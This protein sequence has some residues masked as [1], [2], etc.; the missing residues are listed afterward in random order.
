MLNYFY[1]YSNLSLTYISDILQIF[2]NDYVT[3]IAFSRSFK[4][5]FSK[6]DSDHTASSAYWISVPPPPWPS[7]LLTYIV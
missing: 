5:I 1:I 7:F 4:Y 6:L 2:D 3:L